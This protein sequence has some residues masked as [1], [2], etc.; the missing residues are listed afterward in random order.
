MVLLVYVDNIILAKDDADQKS[1]VKKF[2]DKK[3]KIKDLSYLSFF[4]GL[5]VTRLKQGKLINYR[6][7]A[8]DI[9]A[10]SGMLV[11][12]PC[13]TPIT[14]N[15]KLSFD[16]NEYTHEER[17]YRRAVGRLLYLTI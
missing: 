2:L 4:L 13:S 5:K 14:K 1:E 15:M 3:F 8:L 17:T 9:L 6:K 7:Y 10:K 12:K 16:K 11:G